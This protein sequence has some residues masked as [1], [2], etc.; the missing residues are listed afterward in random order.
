MRAVLILV[1]A[2]MVGLAGGYAWS[3]TGAEPAARTPPKAGMMSLPASPDEQPAELDRQW[4]SRS[5]DEPAPAAAESGGSGEGSVHYPGC[6]V[7]R[8]AGK[9][10]LYEGDPGYR[11]EMD[12]DGDGI[13][14]EPIRNR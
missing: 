12:G 2:V 14:C 8:A 3:T 4:A 6:N 13:A 5:T 1:A 11:I 9:A 7:V 10:P